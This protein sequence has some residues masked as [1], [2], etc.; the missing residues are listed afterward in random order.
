MFCRTHTVVSLL[1]KSS[2]ILAVG[3]RKIIMTYV[4]VKNLG[5]LH[6]KNFSLQSLMFAN[7]DWKKIYTLAGKVTIDTRMRIF[8]YKILN[9]ILYLNRQLF[10][11]K[12]VD[13]PFCSLCSHCVEMVTH[14]FLSC[15]ISQG[16]W[17][18]IT[19]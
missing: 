7:E 15:T 12:L 16:L 13:S 14:L 11:M 19:E 10:R 2:S 18:E 9:N 1:K 5:N 4:L 6:Q 8:Q 17:D 3:K